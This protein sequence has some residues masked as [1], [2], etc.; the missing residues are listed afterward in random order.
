MYK[1]IHYVFQGKNN[2]PRVPRYYKYN[3]SRKA[4]AKKSQKRLILA[5]KI[6]TWIVWDFITENSNDICTETVWRIHS[7]MRGSICSRK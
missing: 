5:K 3:S 4:S 2:Y 6:W 7:V 1:E